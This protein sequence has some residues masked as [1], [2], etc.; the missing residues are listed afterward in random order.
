[1]KAQ[2][3]ETHSDGTYWAIWVDKVP[4]FGYKK[5]IILRSETEKPPSEEVV[6]ISEL[7]NQ[8]YKIKI[9]A[10]RGAISGLFDKDLNKEL[11]DQGAT[12]QLGEFIYETLGNRSQMEAFHLDDYQ[13]EPLEKVWFERYEEGDI[14][15]TVY[16]K[17]NTK[18]AIKDGS[19]EFEIR[20][21]NTTKRID[22][23]YSIL[24][25]SVT[26]PEGI[27][28]AFPFLLNDGVLSFDVQG[29]EIRAGIDQIPGSTND[30]NVVQNY[31]RV[32]NENGQIMLSSPEI[33]MM[34]FGAINTGRYKAGATPESTHI[35]GWPMNNYWT[36]NFNAEQRGGINW[37]YN[38]SSSTNQSQ[39]E[40]TRFGWNN[41]VPFLVRVLPGGGKGDKTWQKSIIQGWPEN[42]ILVS[43]KPN[44]N[45]NSSILHIRET[46]GKNADLK[47]LKLVNNKP[48]TISQVNVLG[49]K[50]IPQSVELK[51]FET[52]FIK[53]SW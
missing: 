10:K 22:L 45:G 14:W 28:I 12:W 31:A 11:V 17:G 46:D 3:V 4:A 42:V 13:R 8:W 20:L 52:K 30:W 5:Y 50:I 36:T 26:D 23:A 6:E 21:F 15:N 41:R 48:F 2:A 9:D 47:S 44:K 32:Q 33:P 35:Y 39:T 24:K 51:P 40:A 43:S 1:A 53:L 49:E 38:I 18:A 27:Y 19:Y 7:E 37:V 29:G 16:F 25:K 34:Q